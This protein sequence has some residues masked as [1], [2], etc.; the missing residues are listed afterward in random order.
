M[1]KIYFRQELLIPSLMFSF[2]EKLFVFVLAHFFLTPFY[3]VPH[4]LTSLYYFLYSFA[5]S[6]KASSCISVVRDSVP[7]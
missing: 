7:S 2:L 6:M 4:T 5:W 3:N 1:A